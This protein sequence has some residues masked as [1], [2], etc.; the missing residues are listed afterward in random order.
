MKYYE[1]NEDCVKN[2]PVLFDKTG[3]RPLYSL[4]VSKQK[5][6]DYVKAEY[7][8][9]SNIEEIISNIKKQKDVYSLDYYSYSSLIKGLEEKQ[10]INYRTLKKANS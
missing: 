7:D 3:L 5:M 9:V 4:E 10:K 8:F 6:I 2:K 1:L